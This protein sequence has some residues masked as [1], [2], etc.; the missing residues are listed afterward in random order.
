M[1]GAVLEKKTHDEKDI[2]EMIAI[3]AILPKEDRAVLLSNA[4][5]FKALRT[6]ERKNETLVE[7]K[8]G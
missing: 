3:M 7:E 1:A 4:N 2:R 6:I 8:V 5:A